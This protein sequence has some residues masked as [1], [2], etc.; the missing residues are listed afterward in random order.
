MANWLSILEKINQG[1]YI[2]E[3]NGETLRLINNLT[4]ECEIERVKLMH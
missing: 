3:N 2:F 4:E 1:L